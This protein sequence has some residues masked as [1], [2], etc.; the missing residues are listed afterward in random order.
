VTPTS[1]LS[2]GLWMDPRPWTPREGA[3][4]EGR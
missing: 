3:L 1:H 2:R 4:R